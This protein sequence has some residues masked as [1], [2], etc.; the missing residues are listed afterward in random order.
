[1][2]AQ[3]DKE[4]ERTEFEN[5]C[6]DTV[7][8]IFSLVPLKARAKMK[9]VSESWR[10]VISSVR[11]YHPPTTDS[12]LVLHLK[13]IPNPSGDVS[14]ES[15]FLKLH[16]F[17]SENPCTV[18]SSAVSNFHFLIDSRNGLALYGSVKD[19]VWN[20]HVSS[21]ILDQ[22]IALP[23]ANSVSRPC[24][25]NLAFDP[26]RKHEFK[27]HCFFYGEINHGS[28]TTNSL[29]F[30]LESWEWKEKQGRVLNSELILETGFMPGK[31]FLPAV[32]SNGR[33]YLIWSLCLLI[34]DED[35]ELFTLFPLPRFRPRQNPC[36]E[37][38]YESDGKLRWCITVRNALMIWNFLGEE[39]LDD[40]T[41]LDCKSL[42]IN[43]KFVT[44]G[45]MIS[46]RMKETKVSITW[47]SIRCCAFNE[48]LQVLYMHVLP[49]AIVGYSFET[50][51]FLQV[52]SCRDLTELTEVG[53]FYISGI[54]TF[55][56]KPVN[57]LDF[58]K[59]A[60]H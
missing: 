56:F 35:G 6:N 20:Y 25:V 1:M 8:Y 52:W 26:C 22:C 24:S 27:V 14:Q 51:K 33:F 53:D 15:V 54:R 4:E 42:W 17:Q 11:Q 55:R 5:L 60:D 2:A 10:R 38:L 50:K 7:E 43:S 18:Q 40:P 49:N 3:K 45:D 36:N 59:P 46:E 32:Y 13:R 37:L 44:I 41:K 28:N 39:R 12:G 34:F 47:K 23:P 16:D 21:P 19:G 31:C 29:I 30:S 57:L 9:V 58:K 48:D